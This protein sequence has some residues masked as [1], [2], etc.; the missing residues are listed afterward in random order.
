M[1]NLHRLRRRIF[2]LLYVLCILSALALCLASCATARHVSSAHHRSSEQT[3]THQADTLAR[4]ALSDTSRSALLLRDTIIFRDSLRSSLL[5][6]GDTVFIE[7]YH[8]RTMLHRVTV[9]DTIFRRLADS[10]HLATHDRQTS[11]ML[12]SSSQTSSSAKKT[13]GGGPSWWLLLLLL[14]AAYMF[15]YVNSSKR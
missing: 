1:L 15:V 2:S 12:T 7:R 9:R 13:S 8:Q 6:R 14:F 11:N 10:S 4:R 3:A 5:R